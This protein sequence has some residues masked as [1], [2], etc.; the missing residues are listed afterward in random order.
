[1]NDLYVFLTKHVVLF[2]IFVCLLILII[3]IE[4]IDSINS[5]NIINPNDA[6]NMINYKNALILDF[7]KEE[8]FKKNHIINSINVQNIDKI[9]NDKTIKK[10]KEKTLILIHED[11]KKAKNLICKFKK[12]NITN[13]YYILDG[14]ISWNKENLPTIKN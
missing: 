14:M 3:I 1:M 11:N 13:I 10:Y 7:R 12:H 8:E 4:F 9:I 2:S 5:K 6:I